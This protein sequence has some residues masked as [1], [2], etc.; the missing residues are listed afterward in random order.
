MR[1]LSA[2]CRAKELDA[3]PTSRRVPIYIAQALP[4]TH[5]RTRK[6]LNNARTLAG[7]RPGELTLESPTASSRITGSAGDD[8][9]FQRRR[10]M[11]SK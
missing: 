4:L 7:T 5:A 6:K 1:A 2:V 3:G 10:G 9:L 8:A 11:Q